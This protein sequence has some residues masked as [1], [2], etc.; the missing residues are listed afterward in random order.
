MGNDGKRWQRVVQKSSLKHK[1]NAV[2]VA[3]HLFLV[4]VIDRRQFLRIRLAKTDYDKV[5]RLLN[6]VLPKTGSKGFAAFRE[7]LNQYQP[8]LLKVLDDLV[9][10]TDELTEKNNA[11]YT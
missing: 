7:A 9:S 6:D 11:P 4:S 10:A 5:D 2:L 3:K 1:L 8:W